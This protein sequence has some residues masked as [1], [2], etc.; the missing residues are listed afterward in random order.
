M[1]TLLRSC[2]IIFLLLQSMWAQA[3][4]TVSVYYGKGASLSELA[5]FDIS[6]I[7]S[8]HGYD[9]VAYRKAWPSSELYAY[10]SVAEA[11]LERKYFAKIPEA[12]K[13]ARNG[14]WNSIVIDQT[15]EQWP[16]FFAEEVIAPLWNKG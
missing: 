6:V 10:A 8:E 7:E 11:G 13:M 4:P 2:L 3:S 14:A 1:S 5:L 15:P 9:P 16:A 12:W